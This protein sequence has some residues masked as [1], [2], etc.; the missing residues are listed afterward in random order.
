M[1]NLRKHTDPVGLLPK[2]F[3]GEATD[4]EKEIVN[5]WIQSSPENRK[6]YDNFAKLWDLT[7]DLPDF[8]INIDQEWEKLDTVIMA[9]KPRT[10]HLNR[11][12]SIAASIIIISGLALWGIRSQGYQTVKAPVL[13]TNIVKLP[14]GSSIT[15][16]AGSKIVYKK[17]FGITHR[18]LRLKGEAYF[19]V[20]G[21]SK[22]IFNV[23]AGDAAVQVTGTKF[24]VKAYDHLPDI[25]VLVTEGSVLLYKPNEDID[26]KVVRSGETGKYD[27]SSHSITKANS[28]SLNDIAW[29]T[30]QI[31][32]HNTALKEVA[33]VLSNTY[34]RKITISDEVQHCSVTV[35][36][37][38][39]DFDTVMNI[40]GSTLDLTITTKGKTTI[41]SGKGC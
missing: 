24:N 36:F 29:K 31:E 4:N 35:S 2:V 6:Q 41:I 23:S 18:N 14:D 1:E 37:D 17:G 34:H 21:S 19:E 16:N 5:K 26:N 8:H 15:L 28:T 7:G 38:N 27:R 25:S 3:S 10:I 30:G 39:M 12:I 33:V 13:A 22:L 9:D 11:I 20:A 32:F 40:L